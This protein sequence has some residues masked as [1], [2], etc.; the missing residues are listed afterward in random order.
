MRSSSTRAAT[1]GRCR[2]WEGS[3]V[4]W[5]A[6]LHKELRETAWLTLP[7]AALLAFFMLDTM[8]IPVLPPFIAPGANTEIPFVGGRILT[9]FGWI[10]GI[11]ALALG[12]AQS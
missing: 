10:I 12:F 5:K 9:G 1:G 3:R 11:L 4:M 2:S 8:R 6:L 7:A